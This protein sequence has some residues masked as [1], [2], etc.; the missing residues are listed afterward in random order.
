MKSNSFIKFCLWVIASILIYQISLSVISI[1]LSSQITA[2]KVFTDRR[3]S[4]GVVL[5]SFDR[6]EIKSDTSLVSRTQDSTDNFYNYEL[7]K[8]FKNDRISIDFANNKKRRSKIL[9]IHLISKNFVFRVKTKN[10]PDYLQKTSPCLIEDGEYVFS[11]YEGS[12][13]ILDFIPLS[14]IIKEEMKYRSSGIMIFVLCGLI[15]FLLM[16]FNVLNRV[17]VKNKPSTLLT[18]GLFILILFT[19][20]VVFF[21]HW[22]DAITSENRKLN[23]IDDFRS[24]YDVMFPYKSSMVYMNHFMSEKL[25]FGPNNVKQVGVGKNEFLFN[26]KEG[27]EFAQ[28]ALKRKYLSES[29]LNEIENRIVEHA[30]YSKNKGIEYM[31]VYYPSKYDIYPENLPYALRTAIK[32]TISRKEQISNRLLNKGIDIISFEDILTKY[33][34]KTLYRKKDTHWNQLGGFYA[35]QHVMQSLFEKTGVDSFRPTT[36]DDYSIFYE[37]VESGDIIAKLADYPY[38]ITDMSPVLFPKLPTEFKEDK[39][40]KRLPYNSTTITNP[41][42]KSNKTLLIFSDSFVISQRRIYAMSFSTIYYLRDQAFNKDLIELLKP[43]VI[44]EGYSEGT[45]N[46]LIY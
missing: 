4:G 45:N 27:S 28:Y 5:R 24:Y 39:N 12:R 41:K 36:L 43:D 38:D 25:F 22:D 29:K 21:M 23:S 19:P 7:S 46:N 44:I 2:I 26:Y 6:N 34:Y 18:N 10:F 3:P 1:V 40:D 20:M 37:V 14:D 11:K 15:V 13:I 9:E 42:A 33:K 16:Y 32:D 17:F 35:T 8:N 31:R 30:E